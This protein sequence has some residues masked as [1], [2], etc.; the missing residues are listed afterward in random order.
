MSQPK[1]QASD[2]RIAK[3]KFLSLV[4]QRTGVPMGVVDQIYEASLEELI[5]ITAS[6]DSVML[7]EFGKFYPHLHKGH[8]VQFGEGHI[9]DYYVLKFSA[10]R[11]IN[12]QLTRLSK[13]SEETLSEP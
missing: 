6:G 7:N 5:E 8:A 4:A 2:H 1:P 11:D 12:R 9:D 3:R 10:T 13:A